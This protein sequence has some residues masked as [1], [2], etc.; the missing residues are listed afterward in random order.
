M[1]KHSRRLEAPSMLFENSVWWTCLF[2]I[3]ASVFIS[4]I[5]L[6]LFMTLHCWIMSSL[7]SKSHWEINAWACT[8]GCTLF[9]RVG[10]RIFDRMLVHVLTGP[11]GHA[12][13]VRIRMK[14]HILLRI[15]LV[16]VAYPPRASRQNSVVGVVAKFS[17]RR[18]LLWEILRTRLIRDRAYNQVGRTGQRNGQQ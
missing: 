17:T 8:N 7:Q 12:T 4:I 9:R 16:S 3:I 13:K 15:I 6:N 14:Y 5:V 2:R 18:T 11:H 10:S 1:Q